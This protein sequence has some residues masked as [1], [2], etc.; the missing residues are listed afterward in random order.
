MK[1]KD[2]CNMK[3]VYLMLIGSIVFSIAGAVFWSLAKQYDDHFDTYLTLAV[4]FMSLVVFVS[5]I[6]PLIYYFVTQRNAKCRKLRAKLNKNVRYLYV[7]L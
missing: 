3:W 2:P 7:Y 5:C 6:C 4:V 1:K